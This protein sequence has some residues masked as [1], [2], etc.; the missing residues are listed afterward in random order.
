MLAASIFID[1]NCILTASHENSHSSVDQNSL[2]HGESLLV[3]SS[4]D[5]ENVTL[6]VISEDVSINIGAH[7]SVVEVTTK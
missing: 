5:S 7:S 3:V 1:Q 4:S 2:F 6:V